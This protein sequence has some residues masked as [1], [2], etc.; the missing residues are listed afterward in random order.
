MGVVHV[1]IGSSSTKHPYIEGQRMR[2][3]EKKKLMETVDT[4]EG[5]KT[6]MEFNGINKVFLKKDRSRKY[7]LRFKPIK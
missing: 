1:L 7:P 3:I 4:L 6:A 5:N 2:A